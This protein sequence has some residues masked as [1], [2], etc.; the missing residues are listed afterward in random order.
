MGNG[1]SGN[2][3]FLILIAV[4][5]FAALSYIATQSNRS[6]GGVQNEKEQ[7]VLSEFFNQAMALRSNTAR[8]MIT[9]GKPPIL[10]RSVGGL[11]DPITGNVELFPPQAIY[12]PALL[13][14]LL[15]T[16]FLSEV[17][18]RANGHEVGSEQQDLYLILQG[19]KENFCKLMNRK[20]LGSETIPL[21]ENNPPGSPYIT[22]AILKNGSDLYDDTGI[23]AWDI[24]YAEGCFG[25][26]AFAGGH[27]VFFQVTER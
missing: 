26:G 19:I 11:Y 7:L 23:G 17:R 14:E 1:Q 20:L 25:T 18:V 10:S 2:V 9:N 24:P 5:L 3:L 12:D 8:F 4:A 13:D 27:A 16:W 21:A 22:S 6:S 15:Y